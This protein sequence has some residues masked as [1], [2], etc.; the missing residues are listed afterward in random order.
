MG[1]K[2]ELR[3]RIRDLERASAQAAQSGKSDFLVRTEID[4]LRYNL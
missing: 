4:N 1:E 2:E 3:Q